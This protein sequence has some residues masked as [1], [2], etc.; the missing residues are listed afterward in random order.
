MYC[1]S[2]Q[3][4][5]LY[6]HK[7]RTIYQKTIRREFM[8]TRYYA[9][10]SPKL[11]RIFIGCITA[12]AV[13]VVFSTSRAGGSADALCGDPSG[14]QLPM[15]TDPKHDIKSLYLYTESSHILDITVSFFGAIAPPD[16]G[17]DTAVIGYIDLDV[18]QNPGT[19]SPSHL[20]TYCGDPGMGMDY[21]V[22]L[23]LYTPG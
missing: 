18:D 17:G 16:S 23:F 2:S 10:F 5:L 8:E 4:S 15:S 13:F 22:D 11:Y 19:G 9:I 7:Y 21:Y 3:N 12:L 20:A 6:I 14:D 1:L